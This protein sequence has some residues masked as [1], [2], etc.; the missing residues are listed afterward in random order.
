M[1]NY[2]IVRFLR[3]VRVLRILKAC[4]DSSQH[5]QCMACKSEGRQIENPLTELITES[6]PPAQNHYM[7]EKNSGEFIFP[8][9]HAG[10]VLAL[11]QIQ[12]NMFLRK[13]FPHISQ[14]LEGIHFG[15]NT[16]RA[17]IR[18]RAN[19]GKKKN[20]FIAYVLVLC[21]GVVGQLMRIIFAIRANSEQIRAD[22]LA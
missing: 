10:L 4:A 11:T 6:Y 2:S 17:C 8:R 7:H 1:R 3:F 15:A 22:L 13:H 18:T 5:E 19:T 16:C 14:I 12:E 20:R 9:T 21:Q